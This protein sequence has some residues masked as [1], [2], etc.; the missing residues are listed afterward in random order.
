MKTLESS[1]LAVLSFLALLTGA[2]GVANAAPQAEARKDLVLRED[3]KC[4]R[5]HDE[6]EEY[7]VLAI[8]KTRHGVMADSRTPT[9][10]S[11]HGDSESHINIPE[12]QKE[13]PKPGL[14]YG[15]RPAIPAD[16]QVDRFFGFFGKNTTT[17]VG[18]RNAAC[19]GCHQG[20]KRIHWAGSAHEARDVACTSCH[21][22]HTPHDKVRD[23]I[24]QSEICF[25]CHKEQRAQIHRP[26]RH[27][28][29]EGKTP[30][31]DCHNPHGTAGP[32]LVVRDSVNETCYMCHMEKRG[33]FVWSHQPVT[34]D[35]SICH[36]PHGS[37][38]ENLLR[39]RPPFLCQACHEP[40]GHRGTIPD[41]TA[42]PVS[43]VRAVVLARGC[44]NCHTN[45]HGSNNPSGLSPNGRQFRR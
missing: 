27:P 21:Q 25:T 30:C 8:G 22:I 13:R 9:C 11:C 32:K 35:C 5:C 19:I 14:L 40:T 20:G 24:A 18:E 37:V 15:R 2:V 31:S 12:G 41:T 29:K 39:Q 34:E 4:T 26:S 17:P 1:L 3:A 16:Q 10:T 33:P 7:P 6:T 38:N 28:I 23:K 44:P 42:G 43:T 45:I 36:N